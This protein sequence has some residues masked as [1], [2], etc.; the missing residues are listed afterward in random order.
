ME[1]PLFPVAG[2]DQA[3]LVDDGYPVWL[4]SEISNNRAYQ[5]AHLFMPKK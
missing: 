5:T 1:L 3:G 4:R 2:A